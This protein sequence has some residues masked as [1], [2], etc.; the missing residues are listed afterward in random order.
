MTTVPM[1]PEAFGRNE[2]TT[3]YWLAGAGF[4]INARGTIL[5]ID[6][7]LGTMQEDCRVSELGLPMKVVYP[8]SVPEIPQVDVVLYTHSDD[9]HLGPETARRL[10]ALNPVFAGPPPVF[11]RL[12]GFGAKTSGMRMCRT[13][14]VFR[15]GEISVEITPADHPWQLLDPEQYGRPFQPGDCCGYLVTTPDCRCFFPGDTRLMEEHLQ[16]PGVELLALDVSVCTYH[17]GHA[18]AAVLANAHRHALLLPCHYG[19]YASDS[20]AQTGDPDDLTAMI[21]GGNERMRRLAPG[22]CVRMRDHGEI[23]L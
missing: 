22:E 14:E 2:W 15:F 8:V 21:A 1:G 16:V 23:L 10:I 9:D 19:T 4:M 20:P 6:P 12:A 3:V 5:L 7:V 13:G 11:A 17:L 18:G